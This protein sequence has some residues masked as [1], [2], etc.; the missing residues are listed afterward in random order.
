VGSGSA[1]AGVVVDEAADGLV[2]D[3]RIQCADG[4]ISA[5]PPPLP[6]LLLLLLLLWLWLWLF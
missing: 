4:E 6:P 2:A 3:E 5:L 1:A